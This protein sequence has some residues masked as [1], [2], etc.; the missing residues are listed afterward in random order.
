[1][2]Y[3]VF[4]L[5]CVSMYILYYVINNDWIKMRWFLCSDWLLEWSSWAHLAFLVSLAL[6]LQ[7]KNSNSGRAINPL[8]TTSLS[9]LMTGYWPAA[10]S[11]FFF[12]ELDFALVH[13]NAKMNSVILLQIV[14][15]IPGTHLVKNHD[16]QSRTIKSQF[17]KCVQNW[18]C[19]GLFSVCNQTVNL[20]ADSKTLYY[21]ILK[22]KYSESFYFKAQQRLN[23]RC[24]VKH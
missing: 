19:L 11:P 6:V 5:M 4:L 23:E 1:M 22:L 8:L 15:V 24:I 14:V 7:E 9:G 3:W 21:S 20:K 10:L 13:K 2:F 12:I 17:K 16:S 18:K